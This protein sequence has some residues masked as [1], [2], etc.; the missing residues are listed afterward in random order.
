MCGSMPKKHC[1]LMA[2][3][4]ADDHDQTNEGGPGACFAGRR[5]YEQARTPE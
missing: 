3:L 5:S 4:D 2:R 1:D